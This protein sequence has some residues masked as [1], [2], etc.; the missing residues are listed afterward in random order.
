MAAAELLQA[1]RIG[2]GRGQGEDIMTLCDQGPDEAGAEVDDVPGGVDRECDAFLGHE[3]SCTAGYV[4]CGSAIDGHRIS[5]SRPDVRPAMCT[6]L[7]W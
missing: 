4:A 1:G 3:R 5:L 7:A 6:D 2:V